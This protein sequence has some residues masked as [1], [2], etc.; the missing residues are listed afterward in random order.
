MKLL[1]AKVA[2]ETWPGEFLF[3]DSGLFFKKDTRTNVKD[4]EL[5]QIAA[6]SRD[7]NT[8][9]LR[10]DDGEESN[11][12]LKSF[13]AQLVIV[14]PESQTIPLNSP[15]REKEARNMDLENKGTWTI[16]LSELPIGPA[17]HLF[18]TKAIVDCPNWD[19]P[20]LVVIGNCELLSRVESKSRSGDFALSMQMETKS[21][22]VIALNALNRKKETYDLIWNA[23]KTNPVVHKWKKQRNERRSAIDEL[24][25]CRNADTPQERMKI[26]AELNGLPGSDPLYEDIGIR[27][28]DFGNLANTIETQQAIVDQYSE[29]LIDLL[30]DNKLR[31]QLSLTIVRKITTPDGEVFEVPYLQIG[32]A[33]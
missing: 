18:L 10:L 29:S 12:A 22:L 31:P 4:K 7:N 6:V 17:S 25:S 33:E 20:P 8:C 32:S 2:H 3:R 24:E 11:A 15:I 28:V 13:A 1:D 27:Q 14:F 19:E 5:V 30:R 9:Y 21:R 26:L 23:N 16:D